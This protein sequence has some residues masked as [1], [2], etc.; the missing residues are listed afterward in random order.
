MNEAAPSGIVVQLSVLYMPV[1]LA[2]SVSLTEKQYVEPGLPVNIAVLSGPDFQATNGPKTPAG[3]PERYRTWN[4]WI[5]LTSVPFHET[6]K[7]VLIVTADSR[8]SFCV[9]GAVLSGARTS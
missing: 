3:V 5:P 2:K 9:V 7:G 1:L 6:A 8:S 4:D